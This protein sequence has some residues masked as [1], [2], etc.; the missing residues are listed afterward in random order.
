[1]TI[2]NFANILTSAIDDDALTT[3]KPGERVFNFGHLATSGD[4]ANGIFAGAADVTVRNF[5]RIETSGLGAAGILVRGDDARIVNFGRV[6]THGDRLDPIP[7]SRTTRSSRKA[8]PPKATGS[9]SPISAAFTSM[10]MCSS[11]LSGVGANGVVVNFGVV[12][13]AAIG[14]SVIAVVGR[15]LARRQCRPGDG[16]RRGEHGRLRF[17]EAASAVNRGT[18]LIDADEER[19]RRRRGGEYGPGQQRPHPHRQ[20]W[21]RRH[22]SALATAITPATRAAS[23]PMATFPAASR[24]LGVP[25]FGIVG[26]DLEIGNSGHITTDGNLAF[27]LSLGLPAPRCWAASSASFPPRTA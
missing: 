10:V 6:E 9:T 25:L 4:L 8:S 23:K 2:V 13:S 20:R 1:M 12:D 26:I 27:G 3:T 15:R 19:G 17:G 16:R 21:K 18:I 11:G 5:G 7:A 14:S 22:G 24:P